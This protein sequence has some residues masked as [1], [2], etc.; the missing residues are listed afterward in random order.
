[1]PSASSRP[2]DITFLTACPRPLNHMLSLSSG[3]HDLRPHI[4]PSHTLVIACPHHSQPHALTLLS[5][6]TAFPHRLLD[7]M[8]SASQTSHTLDLLLIAFPPTSSACLILVRPPTH[9]TPTRTCLICVFIHSH[10][11]T[12]TLTCLPRVHTYL[13]HNTRACFLLIYIL[14]PTQT[15]TISS[16]KVS[17]R[18]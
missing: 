12:H 10:N 9:H 4:R 11:S 6:V 7:H 14:T 13:S 3:L 2:H 8:P 17:F 5:T 1:M 18:L 15:S 16:P